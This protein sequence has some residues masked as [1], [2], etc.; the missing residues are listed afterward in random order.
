MVDMT[1]QGEAVRWMTRTYSHFLQ[2]P[3]PPPCG[4][5]PNRR[6]IRELGGNSEHLAQKDA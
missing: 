5:I 3:V 6:I 4:L 2:A 1:G